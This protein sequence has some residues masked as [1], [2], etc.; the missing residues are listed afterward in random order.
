MCQAPQY[1]VLWSGYEMSEK[2]KTAFTAGCFH[3]NHRNTLIRKLA[4]CYQYQLCCA[5]TFRQKKSLLPF[6]ILMRNCAG[7]NLCSVWCS[8]KAFFSSLRYER[9][10]CVS[11]GWMLCDCCVSVVW[12]LCEC[13]WVW[14]CECCVS[15]VWMLCE[16]CVSECCVSECCVSVVW[17]LGESVIVVRLLCECVVLSASA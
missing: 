1:V 4:I 5:A 2:C 7:D 6:S 10:C 17:V 9:Q 12:L 13:V 16:C 11:V 3:I 14:V 15:V 8:G